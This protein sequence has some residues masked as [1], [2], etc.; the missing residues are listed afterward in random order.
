MATTIAKRDKSTDWLKHLRNMAQLAKQ[1]RDEG[2]EVHNKLAADSI[3][4]R[5]NGTGFRPISICQQNPCGRLVKSNGAPLLGTTKIKNAIRAVEH[6]MPAAHFGPAK[7]KANAK[8]EHKLQASLIH[9]ALLHD[10]DF[11]HCFDDFN[12]VFDELFFVTDEFSAGDIRADIIA[13]GRKGETYFP[14]FIELKVKRQLSR[15]KEQLDA[16]KKAMR[17]GE[18]DFLEFLSAVT[19]IEKRRIESEPTL[20]LIWPESASGIESDAVTIARGE[21]YMTAVF[22]QDSRI[23][24]AGEKPKV[25][26]TNEAGFSDCS[27]ER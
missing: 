11:H 17:I 12:H 7:G 10:L 23:R 6:A 27:V 21:G 16:A 9:W 24:F 15:L 14:V 3:Y 5:I 26:L 22:L 20:I 8:P 4:V 19:G 25:G 2:L 18:D 13:I 1:W